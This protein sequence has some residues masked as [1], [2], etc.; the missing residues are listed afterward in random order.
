MF[1]AS[2]S[3]YLT[4]FDGS[5]RVSDAP[6]KPP[7]GAYDKKESKKQLKSL[8]NELYELQRVLYAHDKF[9]VLCIFQA[10]DAA[11]KDAPSEQSQP[12]STRQDSRCI[13][14]NS[15]QKKN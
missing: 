10:M 15:P 9:A 2:Q 3:P 11:G 5:F 4:P 7:A 8:V 6:T 14:S 1:E 12:E 13:P